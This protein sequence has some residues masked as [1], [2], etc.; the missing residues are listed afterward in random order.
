MAQNKRKLNRQ[1]TKK[2]IPA[3]K[4]FNKLAKVFIKLLQNKIDKKEK[5]VSSIKLL[6]NDMPTNFS[7]SQHHGIIINNIGADQFTIREKGKSSY[8]KKTKWDD[9]KPSGNKGVIL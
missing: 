2:L 4:G 3:L 5:Q 9:I 6:V 7:P 1:E 8:K